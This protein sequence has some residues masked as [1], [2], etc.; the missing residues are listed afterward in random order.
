[1]LRKLIRGLTVV[2]F[3]LILIGCSGQNDYSDEFQLSREA[4]QSNRLTLKFGRVPSV[5]VT[6]LLR[7]NAPLIRLL[8]DELDAN[9]T[10]RFADSYRG[11]IEGM[12]S[13]EYDFTWMGPYSYV[14]S[15]CAN[16]NSASYRPLVR[17][18]RRN[19]SGKL[20]EEYR[21]IIFAKQNSNIKSLEDLDGKSFAFT[22][23]LSTSGYLFPLALMADA[24]LN[25][26]SSFSRKGF[27]K[28]HDKVV[29]AVSDG[30]Y[31]AGATYSGARMQVFNSKEAASDKLPIIA[32]TK[33]IPTSP[34][35]V[36]QS[37]AKNHPEITN[38]F[39]EV[40][41]SLHESDRGQKILKTLGIARYKKANN[42][43]YQEVRNVLDKLDSTLP[44]VQSICGSNAFS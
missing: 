11:I 39:V 35:T 40:M 7:Q 17:P 18:L 12:S 10:Y 43:D 19:A 16:S 1:M 41:T 6:E 14:L 44:R 24:G 23:K 30:T 31:A 20:S 25:P 8:K 38:K 28:R 5:T 15:E 27:L 22:E 42:D 26:K 3:T 33:P 37:F 36:S 34:I 29:R 32:K 2:L 4:K 9:I 21:G 13:D